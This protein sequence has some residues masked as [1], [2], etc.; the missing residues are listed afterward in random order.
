MNQHGSTPGATEGARLRQGPARL[1]HGGEDLPGPAPR[2]RGR[3]D[4]DPGGRGGRPVTKRARPGDGAGAPAGLRRRRHPR[5]LHLQRRPA[6]P[7]SS[8]GSACPGR[9]AAARSSWRTRSTGSSCWRSAPSPTATTASATTALLRAPFFAVDLADLVRRGAEKGEHRRGHR[10]GARRRGAGPRAAA[11]PLRAPA[12][13]DRARPARA[14]RL[15]PRRGASART[16]ASGWSGSA[17]SASSSSASPPPR[18]STSTAPRPGCASGWTS[19]MAIDPPRPVG[20]DAVQV[21]TI[22]Q[23]KGLEFP[24]VVW[25][26]AHAPVAPRTTQAAWHV[27]RE[28]RRPGRSSIDRASPGRSR[29]TRPPR[30]GEGLPAPPSGAGSCTSPPPAPATCSS[31]RSRS[32]R[33]AT[34]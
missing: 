5:P 10:P 32:G 2:G 12:R 18:G 27:S 23:A 19:R 20:G 4:L 34:P 25:W 33:R 22:H 13:R 24:V 14:D 29:R 1:D 16:A 7:P 21:M 11:A 28:R 30:A 8:T 17:N 15:R 31:C 9:R 6:S 26:D 3:R